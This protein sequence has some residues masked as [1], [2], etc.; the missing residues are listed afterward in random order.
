MCWSGGGAGEVWRRVWW[1]WRWHGG[2]EMGVVLH[3]TPDDSRDGQVK[4]SSSQP[5][6]QSSKSE[7]RLERSCA[8]LI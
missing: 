2:Q 5:V 1:R 4:K 7:A 3:P 8:E 6:K